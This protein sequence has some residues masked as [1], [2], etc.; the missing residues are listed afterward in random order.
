MTH[1]PQ[2]ILHFI[3][4][5]TYFFNVNMC[6][7]LISFVHTYFFYLLLSLHL[8]FSYLKAGNRKKHKRTEKNALETR[9]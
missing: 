8:N 7:F 1:A 2:C 5:Y 4:K 3:L 9:K 6:A